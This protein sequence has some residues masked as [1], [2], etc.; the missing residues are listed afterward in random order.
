MLADQLLEATLNAI[1]H[2]VIVYDADLVVTAL[3]DR[4]RE[5]LRIPESD[6]SLGE[7][8]EKLVQLAAS[9]GGYGGV[10]TIDA[11]VEQRMVLARTFEPLSN[12]QQLGNGEFVE[13]FGQPFDGGNFVLTF[14]D[15]TERV[16]ANESLR[17]LS[18]R[19]K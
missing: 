8:F 14:T 16:R 18:Q 9:F 5:I 15:I 19:Y 4:A 3:N 11:R 17:D 7:P 12:D 13:V 10:G 1:R 2:G 6:F